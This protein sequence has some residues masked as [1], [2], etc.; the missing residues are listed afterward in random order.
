MAIDFESLINKHVGDDGNIPA[1]SISKVAN[2]I[3]S[4]VGRD[5]VA[6]DR[7]NAKLDEIEQLKTDKQNAEDTATTAGKWEKKY[8]DLKDQFDSYKADT[9][10]KEKLSSIKA[11]YRKLLEESGIDTKRL[12]T[13]IRATVFDGMKLGDDGKLEKSD[14][15][16][17]AIDSDWADFKVSTRTDGTHVENPPKDNDS[18]SGA[19]SRA[20]ELARQFHERRYGKAPAN[21]GANNNDK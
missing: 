9:D 17:K 7:Y 16:K 10:A 21:D 6:R 15:L 20:A 19:N 1:A 13:I 18:G 4:A 11:A 2:A 14:E 12:D 3:S 5:F 8:N